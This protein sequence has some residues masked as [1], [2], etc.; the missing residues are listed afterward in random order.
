MNQEPPTRATRTGRGRS[1]VRW[2][3]STRRFDRAT[4]EEHSGPKERVDGL[5]D[6]CRVPEPERPR[7]DDDS[8]AVARDECER[9]E[10]LS[11][12]YAKQS[13]RQRRGTRLPAAGRPWSPT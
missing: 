5:L 4:D 3:A 2:Q 7:R 9:E 8:S 1:C 11:P 13:R 10:Q 12:G 6:R